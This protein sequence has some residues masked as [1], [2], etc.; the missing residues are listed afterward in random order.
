MHKGTQ[1]AF[2][3][4]RAH[5]KCPGIDGQQGINECDVEGG[6]ISNHFLLNTVCSLTE[7]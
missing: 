1:R 4:F 5:C 7:H 2:G 3:A 6:G